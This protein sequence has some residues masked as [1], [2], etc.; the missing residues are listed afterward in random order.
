MS[1]LSQLLERQAGH[2]IVGLLLIV[3]GAVLYKLSIPKAEDILILAAGLI[4]RSMV[5]EEVKVK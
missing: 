4:A 2:I 5:A 3:V 1:G